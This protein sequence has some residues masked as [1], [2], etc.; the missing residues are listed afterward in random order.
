MRA[1]YD[2]EDQWGVRYRLF[3]NKMWIS[4]GDH[5]VG[6]NIIHLVLAKTA[7][8]EG[9]FAEGTRAISLFIV[10]KLLPGG[11]RNDVDV[12]GLNHKLGYRGL[13]N[14]ALNFGAGRF[15]PGN[16]PGA[17]GWRIGEV[18]EGLP[19]MFQMM[20]EAPYQCGVSGA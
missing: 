10:P 15:S 14:C 7:I 20:N 1:V 18:G 6:E 4:A 3:G 2:G 13:P 9:E 5:Q 12:I 17:I 16:K 19:Q 8:A 11:S